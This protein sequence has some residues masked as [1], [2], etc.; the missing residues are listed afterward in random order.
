MFYDRFLL[1]IVDFLES[2]WES[3]SFLNDVYI[4]FPMTI[5]HRKVQYDKATLLSIS[6]N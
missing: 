5:I 1:I 2:S 3:E 4:P 6:M